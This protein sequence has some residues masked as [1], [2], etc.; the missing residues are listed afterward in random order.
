[1]SGASGQCKHHKHTVSSET[2]R[3]PEMMSKDAFLDELAVRIQ[4]G[5]R[6]MQM[7]GHKVMSCPVLHLC[8]KAMQVGLQT[9]DKHQEWLQP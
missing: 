5:G 9:T 8:F 6:R 4:L 7:N 3:F 1:M 2:D